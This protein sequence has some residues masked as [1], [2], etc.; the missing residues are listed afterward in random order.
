MAA[1]FGFN[2]IARPATA[3]SVAGSPLGGGM[4]NRATG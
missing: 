3:F 1:E 2:A 4:R